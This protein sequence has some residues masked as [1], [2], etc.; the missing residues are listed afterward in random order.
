M[1]CFYY[2]VKVRTI[3]GHEDVEGEN[4]YSF[5]CSLTSA[6]DEGG[7]VHHAPADLFSG[8]R[9]GTH[10]IEGWVVLRAGL[11]GWR[12]FCPHRDSIPEPSSS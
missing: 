10:C 1:Q 11:E 9:P 6:L 12:K 8:K 7:W 3:T 2:A 5:M 4:R